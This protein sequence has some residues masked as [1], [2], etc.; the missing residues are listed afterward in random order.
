MNNKYNVGQR[1]LG[2]SIY[3]M[4]ANGTIT[5]VLQPQPQRGRFK[6]AVKWDDNSQSEEYEDKL[7]I[8]RAPI[9]ET[10]VNESDEDDDD[11]SSDEDE[12]EDDDEVVATAAASLKEQLM[13]IR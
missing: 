13:K 12:D 3:A 1:V 11:E 8:S 4:M 6:Y 5:E 2:R 10:I 7:W 9:I